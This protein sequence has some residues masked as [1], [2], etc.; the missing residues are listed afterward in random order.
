MQQT[1]TL[2]VVQWMEQVANSF[3]FCII[4]PSKDPADIKPQILMQKLI[5]L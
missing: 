3:L 4:K 1:S 2:T 5:K